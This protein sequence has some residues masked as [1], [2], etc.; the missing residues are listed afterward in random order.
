MLGVHLNELEVQS[1]RFLISERG[2]VCAPEDVLVRWRI[3][4]RDPSPKSFEATAC[5][6]LSRLEGVEYRLVPSRQEIWVSGKPWVFQEAQVSGAPPER[7]APVKSDPG[8]FLNYD[9]ITQTQQLDGS[10]E[11]GWFSNFGVLIHSVLGRDFTGSPDFRRLES[12]WTRDDPGSLT[13][14]RMGD[15]I[16]RGGSWGVPVRF[17]GFQWSTNFA[18]QPGFL[19]FPTPPLRGEASL[20][21]SVDV[22]VDRILRSTQQVPT[23]PFQILDVPMVTGAGEV[24][25]VVR[26]LLGRDSIIT[27]PY[28]VS[29]GI[30]RRG[31]SDFSVEAGS[32]R[33]GFGTPEDA[34]GSIFLSGTY[35]RGINDY[36]TPEVHFEISPERRALGVSSSTLLGQVGTLSGSV[37]ACEQRGRSSS[38]FSL[39]Y[40]R[41]SRVWNLGVQSTL[42]GENFSQLGETQDSQRLRNQWTANLGFNPPGFG[43]FSVSYVDRNYWNSANSSRLVSAN[44]GFQ[45]VGGFFGSIYFTQALVP[46][47]GALVGVSLTRSLGV[48]TSAG[49]NTTAPLNSLSRPSF[50]SVQIQQ[51]LQDEPGVGYRVLAQQGALPR[52]QAGVFL[53][54]YWNTVQ[55]EYAE[56]PASVFRLG[57]Q[58]SLTLFKG[59]VAATRL[60]NDSFALVK[61]NG[62]PGVTVYSEGRRVGETGR[63]GTLLIPRLRSYDRNRISIEQQDLPIGAQIDSLE[64][65][66]TPFARSG[67]FVDF[68]VKN[69][70]SALIQIHD[71][72]GRW[73]PSGAKAQ[74]HGSPELFWIAL[75]GE[76]FVQT[77]LREFDLHVQ[78]GDQNCRVRVELPDA[79]LASLGPVT[80]KSFDR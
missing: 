67:V 53:Q 50:S 2:E 24:Q 49:L 52:L 12:R 36:W 45:A 33:R 75:R 80:C 70:K 62:Y 5:H 64:I 78:W 72:K 69:L 14:Y 55:L 28:Y 27:Q 39:Q 6:F 79:P 76:V 35:R 13:S 30:L 22:Y 73:I 41:Q 47:Q 4:S 23:G 60:L 25:L 17:A 57:T 18:T 31:L 37:A 71:E 46:S 16:S 40:R 74:I 34:Y 43:S 65:E 38:L 48:R 68:P 21:S 51:S 20:P 3:T 59:G 32:L 66:V 9:L 11:G 54:S 26:D 8:L 61:V 56:S 7:P 77:S 15:S 42:S 10:F 63:N 44:Y 29:S 19:T 1:E 58:G